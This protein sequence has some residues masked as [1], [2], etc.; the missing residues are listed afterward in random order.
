MVQRYNISTRGHISQKA[1]QKMMQDFNYFKLDAK[2]VQKAEQHM[3]RDFKLD[4]K[5]TKLYCAFR[6]V[7]TKG[8]G[9]LP[10]NMWLIER[11][12]SKGRLYQAGFDDMPMEKAGLFFTAHL[13]DRMITRSGDGAENRYQAIKIIMSEFLMNMFSMDDD[14]VVV[15]IGEEGGV[16]EA[17]FPNRY[18]V[19]LGAIKDDIILIKTFVGVNMLRPK[20]L[21]VHQAYMTSIQDVH[22]MAFDRDTYRKLLNS[23]T[24]DGKDS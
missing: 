21:S 7:V 16:I 1:E 4:L 6:I 8:K 10:K 24:D 13:F 17:I 11:K 15:P 14:N 19:C 5:D 23:K 9:V 20:Q 12:T 2:G 22:N 18:G 3:M